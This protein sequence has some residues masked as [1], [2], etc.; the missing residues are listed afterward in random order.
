MSNV[1]TILKGVV[2]GRTIELESEPGLPEGQHVTVSV[3]PT[4]DAASFQPGDGIRRSAGA[5]GD[6]IDG[7]D[8]FLEW[9]RNQRKASRPGNEPRVF[10]WIPIRAPRI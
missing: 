4:D 1:Q 6:D 8:E 2:H 3:Q 7:L 9:N 5:W 10:C